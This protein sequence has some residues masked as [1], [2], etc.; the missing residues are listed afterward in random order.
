VI[1]MLRGRAATASDYA[2]LADSYRALGNQLKAWAA[3][4][5]YID[6]FPNAPRAEEYRSVVGGS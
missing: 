3:M 2:L 5:E 4:R 6:R 1:E